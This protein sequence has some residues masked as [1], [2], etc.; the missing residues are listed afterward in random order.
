MLDLYVSHDQGDVRGPLKELS[1]Q[2]RVRIDYG[3]N[4][5]L[6]EIISAAELIVQRIGS[7]FF[8]L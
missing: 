3:L 6:D 2:I 7:E 1:E 5:V 4:E 8:I